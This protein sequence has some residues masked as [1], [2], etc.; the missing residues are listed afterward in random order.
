MALFYLKA[1]GEF[2]PAVREWESKLAADKTWANIKIFIS[3]EYAKENKQNKCTT[4][5]FKVNMIQ[6]QAEAMEELIAARTDA[7]THQ[8]EF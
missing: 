4:K 3:A 2:N 1:A 5:Q 8:M 7:H 6:K